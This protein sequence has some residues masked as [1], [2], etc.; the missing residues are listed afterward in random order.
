MSNEH[1]KA[2]IEKMQREID[3]HNEQVLEQKM[4]RTCG[5]DVPDEDHDHKF[6]QAG[7]LLK[8]PYCNRD[9]YWRAIYDD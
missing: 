2:R 5:R 9:C 6:M 3:E 7:G 8:G 4:C 1:G